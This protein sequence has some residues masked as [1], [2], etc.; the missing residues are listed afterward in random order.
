MR[1]REA[2]TPPS[3]AGI[4]HCA[5]YTRSRVPVPLLFPSPEKRIGRHG[6]RALRGGCFAP[7]FPRTIRLSRSILSLPRGG[8][9][10]IL[11]SH[12]QVPTSSKSKISSC[13]LLSLADPDATCADTARR[14]PGSVRAGELRERAASARDGANRARVSLTGLWIS[15]DECVCVFVCAHASVVRVLHHHPSTS[16]KL[17]SFNSSGQSNQGAYCASGMAGIEPMPSNSECLDPA[18]P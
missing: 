3:P 18:L 6:L 14:K 17:A 12:I 13:L 2:R 4:D 8:G 1:P 10:C 7:T 16:G 15:S 11:S 5:L 9:P